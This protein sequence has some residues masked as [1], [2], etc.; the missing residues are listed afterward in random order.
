MLAHAL[1]VNRIFSV[2]HT[3][4]SVT[5]VPTTGD[6][7]YS[8]GIVLKRGVQAWILMFSGHGCNIA[9]NWYDGTS[10]EGWKVK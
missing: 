2:F 4:S 3:N 6:W 7:N 1:S 5:N 9:V 8:I 10:W